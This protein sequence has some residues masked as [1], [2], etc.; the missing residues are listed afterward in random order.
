MVVSG[1]NVGRILLT[2]AVNIDGMEEGK[3]T[4]AE[5]GVVSE[6]ESL[7]ARYEVAV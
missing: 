6:N 2:A 3:A 1:S 5:K 7:S 4:S